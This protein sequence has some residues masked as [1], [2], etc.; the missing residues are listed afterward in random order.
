[1]EQFIAKKINERELLNKTLLRV[2][3]DSIYLCSALVLPE[4]R[5][6]GLAKKLMIKAIKSIQKEFPITDLFFWGFST[7]GRRL[8]HSIAKELHLLV[9]QR[10]D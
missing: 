4:H 3:Y 7:A 10:P 8:A 1:M 9:H 5:G 2:K 6:R